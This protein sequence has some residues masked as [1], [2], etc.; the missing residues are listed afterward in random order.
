MAAL[1]I[2]TVF[3]GAANHS[4]EARHTQARAKIL[5]RA[6][7]PVLK[8][9][10]E[11]IVVGYHNPRLIHELIEAD[12]L[13]GVFVTHHNAAGRSAAEI[14]AEI[15]G[16]QAARKARGMPLLWITTDQEGGGVSR[17]SPP[18]PR[19]PFLS[20]LLANTPGEASQITSDAVLR[21]PG[22]AE[23]FQSYGAEQ[24]RG[25][26]DLGVN[27]N[28]SP[29]VDLRVPAAEKS[30]PFMRW[31]DAFSRIETR[32]IHRSPEIVAFAARSYARG[33]SRHGV[34]ATF[35]HFPGLGRVA[36][37]TH[38][39]PADVDGSA[40]ALM[41]S[42]WLPFYRLS[43]ESTAQQ[44]RDLTPW[45]MLGHARVPAIDPEHA[46]S[47]SFAIVDGILRR[48]WNY[49]GILITDDF[50]MR[51]VMLSPGGMGGAAAR[52]LNA[53]VDLILISYDGENIYPVLAT[54][55]QAVDAGALNLAQI[56][57]SAERLRRARVEREG[58][59]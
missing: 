57:R 33:L 41:R 7:D 35:K 31:M 34:Y 4:G 47:H 59:R 56:D 21:D 44:S 26:A 30:D 15:A 53:G 40:E 55:L 51:P 16:F 17:L 3:I 49:E 5:N 11:H 9:I 43:G 48:S 32:A 39:F 12:A 54:L 24:A 18:L 1:L 13:G 28:F 45:I 38:W 6:G 52:A 36:A 46:A 14:R 50:N 19:Q 20:T 27:V 8:S 10:A 2:V 25:L 37:D 58:L 42:D 22:L 29:V 23:R